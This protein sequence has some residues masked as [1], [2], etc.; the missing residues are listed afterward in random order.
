[1][2]DFLSAAQRIGETIKRWRRELHQFPE[3]GLET[4][5]TES[6]ICA[7]LDEMG[8]SYRKG[9]GGHGVA[10]VVEGNSPGRCF[11]IRCDCDG[12]PIREESGEPF[13][14]QNGCMHACGHDAHS[15]IGLGT[16]S[17]LLERT[18][19]IHGRVKVIFQPGEETGQ[20][21]RAMIADDCLE[22]PKVDVIVSL[23]VS[24]HWSDAVIGDRMGFRAGGIMACMDRFDIEVY[25]ECGELLSRKD[26]DVVVACCRTVSCLQEIVS[27]NVGIFDPAVISV[28]Q[29]H[30]VKRGNGVPAKGRLVGTARALSSSV[31][32][33]LEKRI[34]EV[35]KA[36]AKRDG[37][38]VRYRYERG[39]P[40]LTNDPAV[41]TH[42][43]TTAS[44]LFGQDVVR[45]ESPVMG[46]EDFA[47]YLEK[48][49]GMMLLFSTEPREG[50]IF[51][52]HNGRY[53]IH[54][55]ELW[56]GSALFAQA[57]TDW[58]Y[59]NSTEVMGN[60]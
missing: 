54:D 35:A 44:H 47:Y 19:D 60:E 1:M 34:G 48:V 13:A 41:T 36:S 9:V 31:R 6:F 11:A 22:N 53:R 33:L 23:H 27:R 18:Q 20:G 50:K 57:A 32:N 24:P 26:S 51:S 28:C 38:Q 52:G 12:L 29:I 58:L 17:L 7:R 5:L 46:G 49:P 42:M 56:R 15:A 10:A 43:E 37:L 40:P 8:V 39:A 21:A 2:E 45:L 55:G 14:S 16:I 3:V 59:C 25:E 4:P 30:T